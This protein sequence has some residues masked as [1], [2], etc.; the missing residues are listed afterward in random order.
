MYWHLT[1]S[2]CDLVSAFFVDCV[3]VIQCCQ[4]SN[5]DVVNLFNAVLL[6]IVLILLILLNSY[7]STFY[8]LRL[9][10]LFFSLFLC[11]FHLSLCSVVSID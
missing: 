9:Q 4:V 2:W 10:A 1:T 6:Y 11:F 7:H 8:E 3:Y 5:Y